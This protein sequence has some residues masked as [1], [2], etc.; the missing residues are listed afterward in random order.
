MRWPTIKVHTYFAI[1]IYNILGWQN[2][3]R[4]WDW[5]PSWNLSGLPHRQDNL[6]TMTN[7][8][9]L[10]FEIHKF[11]I[12]FSR[13]YLAR[14]PQFSEDEYFVYL[15]LRNPQSDK[16]CDI[17]FISVKL[18]KCMYSQCITMLAIK[19]QAQ[20]VVVYLFLNEDWQLK[21]LT[22]SFNQKYS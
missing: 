8:F 6:G 15:S 17:P 10:D 19:R 4:W 9:R 3:E 1:G 18:P 5:F 2:L 14:N 16:S 20:D 21:S 11:F 7:Y 13:C 12:K 22:L